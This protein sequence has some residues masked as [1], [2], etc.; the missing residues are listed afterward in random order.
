LDGD[1]AGQ[2][3]MLSTVK[4]SLAVPGLHVKVVCIP[5]GK[6]PDEFIRENGVESFSELL[7]HTEELLDFAVKAKIKQSNNAN[8]TEIVREEFV[9]WLAQI[10]DLLDRSRTTTKIAYY[11]GISKDDIDAAIR[12]FTF[13]AEPKVTHATLVHNQEPEKQEN[14]SVNRESI[15]SFLNKNPF[16]FEI[17]ANTF[18][19]EVNELDVE[20]IRT[21]LRKE[22]EISG[23]LLEFCLEL[24]SF[25]EN[26]KGS[27]S[28]ADQTT[29]KTSHSTEILEL[30][31]KLKKES[32]AFVTKDRAAS[33]RKLINFHR[34]KQCQM[35]ITDLKLKLNTDN[36]KEI[37]L[38][39]GRLNR[40]IRELD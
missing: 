15:S 22:M 16:V 40:E 4:A 12:N 1:T 32:G 10:P 33:L 25:L 17:V 29:W 28:E 34:K 3:A 30:I 6:D 20:S 21:F 14:L 37:L 9:P 18:Y 31:D 27:P 23:D 36:S 24:C 19:A 11:S 13:G 39:V 2:N 5:S 35:A 8:L 26:K 38:E 7:E